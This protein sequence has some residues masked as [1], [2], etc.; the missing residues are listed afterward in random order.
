VA[1]A[2]G[3]YSHVNNRA[4]NLLMI[5]YV[6][7]FLLCSAAAIRTSAVPEFFQRRA[8]KLKRR[9]IR[10]EKKGRLSTRFMLARP[11]QKRCKQ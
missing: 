3:K 6:H 10:A 2:K 8:V 11:Q 5:V 9:G 1:F 7:K 4:V